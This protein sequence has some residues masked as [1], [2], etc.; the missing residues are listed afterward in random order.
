MFELIKSTWRVKHLEELERGEPADLEA[1]FRDFNSAVDLP[2]A[3]YYRQLM[4]AFPDAKVI[5]TVRDA[6]AWYESARKTILR[7]VPPGAVPLSRVIGLI[8][9][10]ARGFPRWARYVN[11]ALYDGLFEGK[12][13]DRE[14]M[15]NLFSR[16]NEEVM[17]TVPKERL[18]VF[19]VRDGWAPLCEF[20]GVDIPD[21][22]FPRSNDANSFEKRTS[23]SGMAK[24]LS[25][26]K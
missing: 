10:N 1:L 17:Q 2:Y 7:G 5:L 20:L 23:L 14:F 6:D 8:S 13:R 4:A 16:W 11:D 15:T 25:G 12:K 21:E 9:K 26:K 24:T 18:L 22:A 3:L 19:E